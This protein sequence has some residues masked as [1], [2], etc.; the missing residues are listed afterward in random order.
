[1]S[2]Y[3]N[4]YNDCGPPTIPV[5]NVGTSTEDIVVMTA[6]VPVQIP[7]DVVTCLIPGTYNFNYTSY[8][9][10]TSSPSNNTFYFSVNGVQVLNSIRIISCS[11]A[12]RPN[13]SATNC[14]VALNAGDIV[15][16]NCISSTN[17]NKTFGYRTM[18]GIRVS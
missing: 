10:C 14:I 3:N 17:S 1:M 9:S 7:G 2:C 18:I 4:I 16:M 13:V 15:R 8:F 5:L 11:N 6:G 12:T